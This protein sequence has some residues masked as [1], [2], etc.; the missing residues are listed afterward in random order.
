M[1]HREKKFQIP[2]QLLSLN[3]GFELADRM[4]IWDS[5]QGYI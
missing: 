4:Q 2:V 1:S 5:N 3:Q